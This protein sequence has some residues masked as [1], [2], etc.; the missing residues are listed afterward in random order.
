M[1]QSRQFTLPDGHHLP[2]LAATDDDSPTALAQ[3]LGAPGGPVLLLAGGDDE[4]DPALL[5][6][7]TQVV[8]RGLVRTLRDLAAQSGRQARCLVRA[9]GAGLPSLLGAAVAD[10]GG[11]LQLLGVA[12]EGL[13]A[14]GGTEQ[15]VPGLSQLVT[16][17][18]GSWADTQHA[19]FDLAEALAG[20]GGRPMVLLMG[21]GS[22]AVAEV[23]QA[24]R[25]GWPVLML[26]GSGG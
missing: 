9:S 26:E 23:L 1:P 20:A 25:R 10:S 21:G 11:G 22:A 24:V 17:P 3:A 8:A 4:I 13:M 16:W 6:R 15:P 12:P 2:W 7:L 5:A 18:G 19:R 14:P